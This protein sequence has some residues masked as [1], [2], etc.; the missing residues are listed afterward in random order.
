MKL[1]RD[2]GAAAVA[3]VQICADVTRDVGSSRS[4]LAIEVCE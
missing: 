2:F 3:A 1:T 4:A